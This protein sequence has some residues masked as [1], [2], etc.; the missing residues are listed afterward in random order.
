VAVYVLVVDDDAD[1]AEM[2]V[3]IIIRLKHHAVAC[4]DPLQA[5]NVYSLLRFDVVI[6]DYMMQPKDGIDVLTSFPDALKVLLTASYSTPE[7]FSALRSGV[8]DRVLTKPATLADLRS[9]LDAQ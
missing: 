8:I 1:I 3:R 2:L 4:S 9:L 6:S 7:I 5:I